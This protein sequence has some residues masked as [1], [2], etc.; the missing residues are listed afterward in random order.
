MWPV[1]FVTI[2]LTKTLKE[3]KV[4]AET[5]SFQEEDEAGL[6]AM[7]IRYYLLVPYTPIYLQFKRFKFM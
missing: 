6:P 7:S 5:A 3:V 4:A 1:C 2:V